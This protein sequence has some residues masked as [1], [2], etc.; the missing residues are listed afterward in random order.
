MA[1]LNDISVDDFDP[2]EASETVQNSDTDNEVNDLD[3]FDED[4]IEEETDDDNEEDDGEDEVAEHPKKKSNGFK[5]RIDGLI[6]KNS[7]LE[8]RLKKFEESQS[9]SKSDT[10]EELSKLVKPKF[11]DF[12]T[13]DEFNDAFEDYMEKK[14]EQRLKNLDSEKAKEKEARVA[15]E[16]RKQEDLKY[17]ERATEAAKR[18]KNFTETVEELNDVP[19]F[20]QEAIRFMVKSELGPDLAFYLAKN[21]DKAKDLSSK[22][23]EDQISFLTKLEVRISEKVSV[24]KESAPKPLTKVKPKSAEIRKSYTEKGISTDDFIRMR[25]EQMKNK[26]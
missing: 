2:M 22:S 19:A 18:Y 10:K 23:V 1:D 4:D 13:L 16:T 8:E 5:K 6:K 7:E 21:K 14:F 11:E 15:E 20:A 12:D 9:S 26:R 24:K 25:N 17:A 3:Y